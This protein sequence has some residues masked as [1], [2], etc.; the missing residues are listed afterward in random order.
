MP[1]PLTPF[2]P[3][4]YEEP[5]IYDNEVTGTEGRNPSDWGTPNDTSHG[6]LGSGDYPEYPGQQ[7]VMAPGDE[8]AF[9]D[10]ETYLGEDAAPAG[11]VLD[12]TPFQPD[13]YGVS[14]PVP[15]TGYMTPSDPAHW[16]YE[17]E[18][19][20]VHQDDQGGPLRARHV[21]PLQQGQENVQAW[22]MLATNRGATI[23]GPYNDS[24]LQESSPGSLRP[25]LDN[26]T[27][28]RAKML[29][30]PIVDY[31]ERPWT[32]NIAAVAGE[33]DEPQGTYMPSNVYDPTFMAIDGGP[34]VVYQSPPDPVISAPA[35]SDGV[36][37][38]YGF[39]T[40]GG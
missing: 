28:N 13:G 5:N 31:G 34:G 27:H 35:S 23:G 21:N 1:Q 33:S 32:N 19:V 9:G 4:P 29:K 7:F 25:A 36:V 17:A 11:R 8:F 38:D 3:S 16:E 18:L 10:V 39:T 40:Y 2:G 37:Y 12:T 20:Q 6:V 15:V 14:V 24:G 22:E 30:V 26:S